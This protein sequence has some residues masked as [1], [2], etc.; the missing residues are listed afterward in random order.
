LYPNEG[1]GLLDLERG[2][3]RR[4]LKIEITVPPFLSLPS[5]TCCRR[6]ANAGVN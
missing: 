5:Q 6:G 3:K 4:E 2:L 1:E